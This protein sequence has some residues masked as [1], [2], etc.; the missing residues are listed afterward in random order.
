VGLS[1]ER[2]PPACATAKLPVAPL[3]LFYSEVTVLVFVGT[4]ATTL[5]MIAPVWASRQDGY[6]I[7]V[8]FD[9]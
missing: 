6:A 4:V 7:V 9:R 2:L 1:F 8:E 3:P 5:S